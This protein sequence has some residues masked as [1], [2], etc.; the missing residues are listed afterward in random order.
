MVTNAIS[1]AVMVTVMAGGGFMSCHASL[2]IS[3]AV[4]VTVAGTVGVNIHLQL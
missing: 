4:M 3:V 1:V 2:S